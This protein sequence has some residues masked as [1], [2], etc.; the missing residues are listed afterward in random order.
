[1][2]MNGINAILLGIV[3]VRYVEHGK[4][5]AVAGLLDFSSYFAA[6]IF[7]A[8]GGFLRDLTGNWAALFLFWTVLAAAGICLSLFSRK[9]YSKTK[10]TVH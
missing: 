6:G 4:V 7:V 5:S 2:M 9:Y 3:P 1:M 10:S 8:A